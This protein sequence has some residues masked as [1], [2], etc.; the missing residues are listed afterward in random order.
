MEISIPRRSS[1]LSKQNNEIGLN[2]IRV[3]APV[4]LKDNDVDFLTKANR[5]ASVGSCV[6]IAKISER[7][8]QFHEIRS[9][10][11]GHSASVESKDKGGVFVNKVKRGSC[12]E[13]EQR[14]ESKIQ[15]C[16]NAGVVLGLQAVNRIDVF[17]SSRKTRKRKRGEE[18]KKECVKGWTKEQEMAL[19]RAYIVAKP[20]PNFWKKVSKLVFLLF[21]GSFVAFI[22]VFQFNITYTN[23]W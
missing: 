22:I 9:K 4:E 14:I 19:Q 20:T 1:R 18:D 16:V 21:L 10:K 8:T 3:L 6:Q 7:R 12:D 11:I 2:K 23:A 17:E 13:I 15:F 5:K